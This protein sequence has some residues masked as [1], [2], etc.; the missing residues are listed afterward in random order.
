MTIILNK[1]LLP[2]SP[3]SLSNINEQNLIDRDSHIQSYKIP[4]RGQASSTTKLLCCYHFDFV[5]ITLS[6]Q[7]Q[8]SRSVLHPHQLSVTLHIETN[9][10]IRSADQMTGSYVKCNIG[11]KSKSMLNISR[12]C[13]E[14]NRV[15]ARFSTKKY[16]IMGISTIAHPQ[17]L[18]EC[19]Q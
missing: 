19:L 9:H 13:H 16:S 5:S 7:K 1:V 4:S 11:P 2:L 14:S 12:I 6:V 8:S 18:L 10:L 17:D 15:R 3:L